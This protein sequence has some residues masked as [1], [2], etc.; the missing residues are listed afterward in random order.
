MFLLEDRIFKAW[1]YLSLVTFSR[2]SNFFFMHLMATR[3]P[4]LV[5]TA[6]K[7]TEKVPLP[8]SCS[9]IYSSMRLLSIITAEEMFHYS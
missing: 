9:N 8:F 6:M 3:S 7:T 5:D 2:E 4:V 1:I